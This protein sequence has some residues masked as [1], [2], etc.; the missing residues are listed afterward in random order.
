[1]E[2]A[3]TFLAKLAAACAVCM[4]AATSSAKFTDSERKRV[5][6]FWS[7]PD[8]YQILPHAQADKVGP[9]QVRLTVEG[10]KWLWNYNSKRGI[11]KT[12]VV[13]V[14]AAQNDQQRVW[15][16][17][18]DSKVAYDRW[19]AAVEADKK[20]EE[21]LGRSVKDLAGAQPAEPG[22]I[23]SDLRT[24]MGEAPAF[25]VAIAPKQHVVNF[26]DV[27]IALTD[28]P[29][30]Q[31]RYAYYR[32]AE[33]VMSG[34]TSV[35]KMSADELNSL[36]K[37]AGID[38]R[39]RN[40]MKAVSLLEGGFDSVNT[41]DTGFVSVGF[42]QFAC[43]SKGS[44]SLGSV[45][46][47]HKKNDPNSFD[48]EFKQYGLDVTPDGVLL[49][50]DIENDEEVQGSEAALQIIKDKRLISV[51]QRAGQK[52]RQFKVAQLQVAKDQYYPGTD[53]VS[54]TIGDRVVTA[55]VGEFIQSE[56]GLAT[57]MD[58]KVNTGNT[59]PLLSL[60]NQVA[61]DANI[62]SLD[63]F[64][65]YER[66]LILALKFRKD[67]TQD[68]SLTQPGPSSGWK[69]SASSLPSRHKTTRGGKKKGS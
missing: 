26:P 45:L 64:A 33:G 20:N 49:A 25:A 23:P 53:V 24:F 13:G 37:D 3:T 1:M 55:R 44:G 52:S 66:D 22:P 7:A 16:A 60:L 62:T 58:R 42:I 31:P 57:L 30:M 48:Q 68:S 5:I 54:V 51:F 56:A 39:T 69:R 18:I 10:S 38:E 9:Y 46:L 15:E 19:V 34:G 61:Q 28:A 27:R 17:W 63:D 14:P 32:W 35:K 47:R 21:E 2:K 65:T 41:Y 67:Y 12:A 40:V 59:N 6:D 43:L 29:N 11:G 4:L 36:F 8:R 50:L